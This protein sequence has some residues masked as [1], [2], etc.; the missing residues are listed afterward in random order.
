M[1][2]QVLFSR[3]KYKVIELLKC[4]AKKKYS[5]QQPDRFVVVFYCYYFSEKKNKTCNFFVNPLLGREMIHVNKPFSQNNN[6]KK[7]SAAL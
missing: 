2:C 7:S 1:K 6:N 5:R 3:K 4:K